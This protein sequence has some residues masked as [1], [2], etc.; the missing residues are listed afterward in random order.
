M[1]T[2][3]S[4]AY[5]GCQ[6]KAENIDPSKIKKFI[7]PITGGRVI[8]CYDGDTITIASKLPYK[9]SELYKFAVRINGIDCPEI[10]S[11]NK[12]EKKCAYIA[13]NKI[14]DLLLNKIIKLENV[15]T[16]KYGRLLADVIINNISV[17]DWLLEQNLAVKYEGKAKTPPDDWMEYYN[18]C[19]TKIENTNI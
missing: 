11:K 15:N 5:N 13:K 1:G 16:E 10:R 2:C 4:N 8:A 19:L 14:E 18:K 7:P 6:S 12:N 9:N 17:G 3:S